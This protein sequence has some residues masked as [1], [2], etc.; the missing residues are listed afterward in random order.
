MLT[1]NQIRENRDYVIERLK[2]KNFK[3][4]EIVNN[5]IRLDAS[6]REIQGHS[7]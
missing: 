2:V 7:L 3:A 1:I 5:I 6:R 4:D